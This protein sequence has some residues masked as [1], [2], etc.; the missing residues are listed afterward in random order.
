MTDLQTHPSDNPSTGRIVVGVDGSPSSVGALRRGIRIATALNAD[1]LAVSAWSFPAMFG[2]YPASNW[3]PEEDAQQ[4]LAQVRDEVFKGEI[5]SWFRG[6]VRQGL[7]AQ[8][9]LEASEG[10]EMLIVGSRGHGGFS[11]LLLGSV[12]STCAEYAK[13]PVL[14]Y[15]DEASEALHNQA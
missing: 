8:V 4:I 14:I 3:S 13:I 1:L 7:P 11:G 12:S 10:A 15:H 5:P 6:E 2:G 9:L